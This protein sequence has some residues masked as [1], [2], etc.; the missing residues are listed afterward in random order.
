MSELNAAIAKL[1]TELRTSRQESLHPP[2][3]CPGC[4][5]ACPFPTQPFETLKPGQ[6]PSELEVTC[7][8][9]M[10]HRLTRASGA[11]SGTPAGVTLDLEWRTKLDARHRGLRDA[12]LAEAKAKHE[13]LVTAG[14]CPTCAQPVP[15]KAGG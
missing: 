11:V 6:D 1:T 9:G 8:C 4:K 14:C 2:F 13:A 10:K 7:G 3:I 5:Q 15:T 12:E